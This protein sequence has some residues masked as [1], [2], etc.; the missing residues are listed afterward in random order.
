MFVASNEGGTATVNLLARWLRLRTMRPCLRAAYSGVDLIQDILRVLLRL[1]AE[2]RVNDRGDLLKTFLGLLSVGV[3]VN[4]GA[5]SCALDGM[6]S[7][8]LLTA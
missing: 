2:I 6:G 4:L 1:G 8:R 5:I 7:F 3:I